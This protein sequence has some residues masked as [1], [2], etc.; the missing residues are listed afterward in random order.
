MAACGGHF[1]GARSGPGHY[2]YRGEPPTAAVAGLALLR[3]M[4][5]A[6]GA[7]GGEWQGL[8]R[9]RKNGPVVVVQL[10]FQGC[11]VKVGGNVL[12]LRKHFSYS[13]LGSRISFYPTFIH[14]V[15][16][17]STPDVFFQSNGCN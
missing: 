14:Y 8:S 12:L 1:V 3:R 5:N 7:G 2:R 4:E 6:G 13:E 17:G 11:H 16:L 10:N 9:F 15:P